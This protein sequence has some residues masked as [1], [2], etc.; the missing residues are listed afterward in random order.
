MRLPVITI[1]VAILAI[2]LISQI[3]YTV[4]ETKQ[5][6]ILQMGEY[7]QTVSNPGLHAKL[8]FVQTAKTLEKRV[9]T[10]DTL[11]E[12]Y[13]TLDKKRLSV[14]HVTRWR[15]IDP[16]LFYVTLGGN[17]VRAQQ[18]LQGIVVSDMKDEL[19][20]YNF[21]DIISYQREQIMSD[22]TSRTSEKALEFGIEVLEVRIKRADLP[23]EVEQSVFD[24]MKAERERIAKQYRAEGEEESFEIR[25]EADREAIV[26]MAEAYKGRQTLEGEG[27]SK[28]IEIYTEAYRQ[29][30][31]LY[32]L[33]RTLQ[34]YES[35]MD[36]ETMLVL[37]TESDLFKYLSG[38]EPE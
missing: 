15:I 17:E 11:P 35:V 26:I 7:K 21:V 32:L 38:P 1:I 8:P 18:R 23:D 10:S 24:R 29:A 31:E 20:L 3:F 36:E 22:V 28:A 34:A 9:I 37:S 19:A 25:A 30:P 4:D 14:D 27:D 33:L 13:I 5:V 12:D 6:I 2:V 16:R